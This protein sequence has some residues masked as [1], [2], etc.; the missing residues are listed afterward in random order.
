MK[1]LWI[2]AVAFYPV[3]WA[4]LA[5]AAPVK[6]EGGPVEGIVGRRA[7]KRRAPVR[8]D[9]RAFAARDVGR[10]GGYQAGLSKW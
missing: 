8:G 3:L 9:A 10:R 6:V 1:T 4:E 5:V 2:A 7:S